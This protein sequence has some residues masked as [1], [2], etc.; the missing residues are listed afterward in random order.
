MTTDLT[1]PTDSPLDT[2]VRKAKLL[3]DSQF[4]PAH[5]RGK[6]ADLL[7]A[8]QL[9]ERI[10]VDPMAVLSGTFVISGKV[11]MT[12]AFMISLERK[13]NIFDAPIRYE[14]TGEGDS[15][16]VTAVGEI[17][18]TR[19]DATVSMAMA[20]AEGYTRNKKYA[21]IPAHML[22]MRSAAWLIRLT[23]PQ[24]LIG[25]HTA[26]EL[27]DMKYA[28]EAPRLSPAMEALNART[29]GETEI[30]E[31]PAPEEPQAQEEAAE[32]VEGEVAGDDWQRAYEQEGDA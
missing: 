32:A 1:T 24:V 13:A 11:G 16:A 25:M 10:K 7:V 29:R 21:T 17:N 23:C 18:G 31:S 2:Q 22:R 3:C 12:T 6:P 5:F 30:V 26:D 19:Y 14:Q 27:E 8:I 20:K 4:V 15:L 9:A 28:E